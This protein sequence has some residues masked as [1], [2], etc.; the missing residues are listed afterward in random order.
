MKEIIIVS[1]VLC[2]SVIGELRCSTNTALLIQCLHLICQQV[3][4]LI[5]LGMF[6][7]NATHIAIS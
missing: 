2:L 4:V 7:W 6:E 3:I 5:L 1:N